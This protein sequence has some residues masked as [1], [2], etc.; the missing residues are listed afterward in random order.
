MLSMWPKPF[1]LWPFTATSSFSTLKM[2]RNL[3]ALGISLLCCD[4]VPTRGRMYGPS[5]CPLC[6]RLGFDRSMWDVPGA[7]RADKSSA[8][9]MQG[10]VA[11]HS[12]PLLSPDSSRRRR[13]HQQANSLGGDLSYNLTPDR[14]LK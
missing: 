5:Q 1:S 10:T 11:S 3:T 4:T 8:N 6:A 14:V 9:Q 12:C 13:A 7:L 2:V